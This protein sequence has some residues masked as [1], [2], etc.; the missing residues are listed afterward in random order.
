MIIGKIYIPDKEAEK[1]YF[2]GKYVVTRYGVYQLFWGN[3][4][5]RPYANLVIN[6]KTKMLRPSE[7]MY[8]SAEQVNNMIGQEILKPTERRS[9]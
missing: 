5:K 3:V 7:Y 9:Q 8:L 6:R 4:Q 1:Q 2:A